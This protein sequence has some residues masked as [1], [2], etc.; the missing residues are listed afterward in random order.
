MSFQSNVL[1]S[2]GQIDNFVGAWSSSGEV[3][4]TLTKGHHFSDTH[5]RRWL[6]IIRFG[7]FIVGLFVV[8]RKLLAHFLNDG[9][10]GDGGVIR[11]VGSP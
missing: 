1:H 8:P 4:G 3:T 7:T 5:L 11:Q 9:I 10:V 6:F 2:V